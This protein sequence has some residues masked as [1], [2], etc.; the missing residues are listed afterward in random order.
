MHSAPADDM[1]EDI[2]TLLADGDLD[3]ASTREL[4]Q[5]LG[6]GA[7]GTGIDIDGVL[8]LAEHPVVRQAVE[9]RDIPD[10]F[11]DALTRAI[12]TVSAMLGEW[13]GAPFEAQVDRLRRRFKREQEKYELVAQ[14]ID[15]LDADQG[16]QILGRYLDTSPAPVF[17]ERMANRFGD[18]YERSQSESEDARNRLADD[19]RLVELLRFETPIDDDGADELDRRLQSVADELRDVPGTIDRAL[20]K[21]TGDN[22]LVAAALAV[23]L[24]LEDQAHTMMMDVARATPQSPQFA[25]FAARLSPS[26]TRHVLGRFLVDVLNDSEPTA[27]GDIDEDA[28]RRA[29]VAART[30]LPYIGGDVDEIDQ[31]DAEAEEIAAITRRAWEFCERYE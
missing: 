27:D 19:E 12:G 1:I 31:V 6:S 16:A 21:S 24:G 18:L 13:T 26:L 28:L 29:I 8:Y 20:V 10:E 7:N 17:S 9:D 2:D 3:E 23:S 14:K 22:T 15:E 30:V 25:A 11:A 4:S 5:L